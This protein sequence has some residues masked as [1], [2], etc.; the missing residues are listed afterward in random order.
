[1]GVKD[2]YGRSRSGYIVFWGQ[3]LLLWGSKLT[4][5]IAT[6]SMQSEYQSYY[7]CITA[8]VFIRNLLQE[9]LLTIRD[10]IKIFSDAKSAI[11]S[12]LNAVFN[13][14]IKYHCIRQCLQNGTFPTAFIRYIPRKYSIAD[15]FAKQGNRED[16]S[17]AVIA[18]HCGE[19]GLP[20]SDYEAIADTAESHQKNSK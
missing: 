11:Q 3:G 9:C 5:A 16:F 8:F 18:L 7:Y 15:T 12:N 10:S 20:L 4:S 13:V 1:M 2:Y 19:F 14:L 17:R 6:S